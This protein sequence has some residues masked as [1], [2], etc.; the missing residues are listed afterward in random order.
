MLAAET[1]PGCVR[2]A[3]EQSG[4]QAQAKP[5]SA[6]M[7][8]IQD[9]REQVKLDN[10]DIAVTQQQKVRGARNPRGKRMG[11]R[12]DAVAFLLLGVR[13]STLSWVFYLL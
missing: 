1:L 6:W 7:L 13:G 12:R 5:Q 8:F 4:S 3:E 9:R 11:S 2:G 10:P